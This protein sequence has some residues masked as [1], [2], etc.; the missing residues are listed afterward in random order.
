MSFLVRFAP[1]SMTTAQYEEVRANL[2]DSGGFP[3][4]GMELHVCFG[5][6]GSLRVTTVWSSMEEFRA[7]GER[8]MPAIRAAGIAS[9]DPEILPVRAMMVSDDPMPADDTGLVVRFRPPSMTMAQYEQV[10]SRIDAQGLLPVKGGLVHVLMGEDG[11]L[12]VGEVW[13]GA[14]A[15]DAFL[16][17]LRPAL[18]GAGLA[19]TEPERFPLHALHV[20]DLARQHATA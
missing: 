5:E 4:K 14:E 16:V 2:A 11:A 10:T 3:P 17:H 1:P 19:P 15:F 9:H 6:E 18:E 7:F 20:T 8:L 12:Q 13:S